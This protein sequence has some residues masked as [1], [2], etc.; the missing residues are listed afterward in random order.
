M[1][2]P[3]ATAT[4]GAREPTCHSFYMSCTDP[5]VGAGASEWSFPEIKQELQD[6]IRPDHSLLENKYSLSLQLGG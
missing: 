6:Q 5:L 1:W 4:S 3:I 2:D